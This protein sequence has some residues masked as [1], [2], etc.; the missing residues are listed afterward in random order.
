MKSQIIDL[1]QCS[2]GKGAISEKTSEGTTYICPEEGLELITPFRT[3]ELLGGVMWDGL[4]YIVVELETLEEHSLTFNL[5]LYKE[6]PQ[7]EYDMR[8][9]FSILPKV[10][11]AVPIDLEL[12][13]SQT[14]FP[15]RTEGRLRM[16][17]YGKPIKIEE[18]NCLKLTTLKCYKEQKIKIKA[19]YLSDSE[20]E[21]HLPEKKLIDELGQWMPKVWEGNVK[22]RAQCNSILKV[23][24]QE[25]E[26]FNYSYENPDWD[27]FGGWKKKSFKKTGWFHTEFDGKRWWL[28][29]PE[30]NA[31]FS[32]GVDCV[33]PGTDSRV[34]MMKNL[35]SWIPEIDS[36][37]SDAIRRKEDG[38]DIKSVNYG[39][40]N[41]ISAF[42]ADNWW[43]CWAKIVKMYLYKWNINTIANWS[44]LEFI[45]FAKMPYVLPLDVH[46][47]QDFPTTEQKIF[48]DFP[49]VF[50]KEYREQA[51][52][53]AKALVSF[54]HDPYMIG[55]FMRNEPNW[56][57]VHGLN[58]AEEMLANPAETVSKETFVRRMKEK[59]TEIDAFNSAW[60]LEL[61]SFEDLHR[62][63]YHACK[64]SQQAEEDLKEFS[65]EMI[66]LYVD[67][68]AKACK[69]VDPNHLNL[70]M[71]YAYIADPVMLSGYENFDVFSINSYQMNPYEQ[72]ANVGEMLD[73]P[74]MLGEFHFGALDK[75]LTSHGLRGVEDQKERGIAYRYY[76]E[77]GIRS[78]HFI[79][80]HYFMLNDQSCIGRF[81][82]ENY[83]IGLMDIC[84]QEYSDMTRQISECNK[85]I[86]EVCSG[87]NEIFSTAAKEIPAV[88]C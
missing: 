24:L 16:M 74:V 27:N 9:T 60:K 41:L 39:I 81:D 30:G 13:N 38:Q 53:Y 5:D 77:Q 6:V 59:Y 36:E 4:K 21:Y 26:S 40:T 76:V 25:A 79:G 29:D 51:E 49:D 47:E 86:Y 87:E 78:P 3:G 7:N 70:G 8:I 33:G 75:G 32:T 80:A 20:P 31:F 66:K 11:V 52:S 42:G 61:P 19:V 10:P 43:Q 2:I 18:V 35:C 14:L 68:P 28:A 65:A 55:Y 54:K 84:M 48:R 82:G 72:V 73:M 83:Q 88:H 45:R 34:D 62:P 56:G 67:I 12:L 23:L 50:S 85:Y 15:E 57:F 58:I 22:D 63:I 1:S 17:V 37:F 64:L 44:S 46:S 69:K 71:R